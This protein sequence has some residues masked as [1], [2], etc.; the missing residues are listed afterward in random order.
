M[1]SFKAAAPLLALVLLIAPPAHANG[2]KGTIANG[3]TVTGTVT[4]NGSDSY[5]FKAPAGGSFVASVGETGIHDRSFLPEIVLTGPGSSSTRGVAKAL[6]VKVEQIN[7]AAGTWTVKVNRGDAGGNSGG[8]YALTLVQVPVAAS[9]KVGSAISG[10]STS[11]SITRGSVAV[12][13]FKGVAG[14][15]AT[16]TIDGGKDGFFP[17]IS[18]F[19]PTGG[20]AAGFGCD[21]GCSQDVSL[22]TGGIYTVVV[23][24][25]DDN[26]V[27]DT[28]KL[29]VK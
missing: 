15:K 2:V 21:T 28:Y 12:H 23:S 26:D 1:T 8:R 4:G 29:S 19:T 9:A 10:G 20:L 25:A 27:T 3:Q 22:T 13:T 5:T 24:K 17:E 11:G 7:A 6:N 16:L 14:H 18:V